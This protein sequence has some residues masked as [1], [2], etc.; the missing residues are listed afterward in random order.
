[1]TEIHEVTDTLQFRSIDRSNLHLVYW[2]R[3]ELTSK[4]NANILIWHHGIGEHSG[5]YKALA[6]RLLSDVPSLDAVCSFDMRNHGRSQGA[7]GAVTSFDDCVD[8]FWNHVMPRL[9]LTYGS[10]ANVILGGHSM[11]AS[12]VALACC[13]PDTLE[14]NATGKIK[15]VILSGSAIQVFL[16]GVTNK[17]LSYCVS[18]L[19]KLPGVRMRTK[20]S[21]LAVENL[22]HDPEVIKNYKEDELIHDQLSFGVGADLLSHGKTVLYKVTNEDDIVLNQKPS[23]ILHAAKDQVTDCEG[24]RKLAAAI[25]ARGLTTSKFVEVDRACHEMHNEKPEDGSKQYFDAVTEFLNEV[26]A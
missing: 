5:R 3:T 9:A 17:V 1:M 13:N 24:S 14:A 12:I 2:T 25:N 7:R 10:G 22:C 26:F 23:L 16:P 11:G 8:D 21:E 18:A 4:P 19:V 6:A 20:N 15:G